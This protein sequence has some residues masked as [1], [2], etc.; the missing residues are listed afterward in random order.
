MSRRLIPRNPLGEV[1]VWV[2]VAVPLAG[3]AY[4]GLPVWS[5]PLVLLGL[6]VLHVWLVPIGRCFKCGGDKKLAIGKGTKSRRRCSRCGGSGE[7]VRW[8]AFRSTERGG[9]GGFSL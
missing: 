4:L 3:C 2:F 5:W 8:R 7:R 9:R 1:P 6:Y